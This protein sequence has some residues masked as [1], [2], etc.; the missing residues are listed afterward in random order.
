MSLGYSMVVVKWYHVFHLPQFVCQHLTLIML[1][2][3][4]SLLVKMRER[5]RKRVRVRER[6]G[7]REGEREGER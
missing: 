1:C 2:N 5:E 3:N 6:E 4:Q 7:R